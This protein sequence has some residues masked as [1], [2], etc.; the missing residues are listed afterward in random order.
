MD[1][2]TDRQREILDFVRHYAMERGYWPSF[3][4]IQKH[5]GFRS[6]NAVM[7]HLRALESKGA[8]ERVPGQARTF[9]IVPEEPDDALEVVDL[10]IYGAIAAGYP[11][12]VEQGDA[13]GRLQ[14]DVVTAGAN[15]GRRNFAL[16]VNGES[17]IDAGIF[18]GDT[19][20]VEA[21]PARHGE[22]VV[23]L[24]DGQSTLKRLIR[25]KNGLSFL[26]SENKAYPE[27]WPTSELV[28]QGVASSVVRRL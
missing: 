2:L 18:D 21:R 8:I 19:V 6:T 11:D 27:L 1:D 12:G 7:G 25:G 13:L 22:I 20:V 15:R 24:I 9:R 3:R 5:F 14:V 26:K 16:R 28:I 23:A 4:E 17:M 10:P